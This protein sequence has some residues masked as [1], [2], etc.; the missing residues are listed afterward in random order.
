MTST[1]HHRLSRVALVLVAGGVF[2]AVALWMLRPADLSPA[3]AVGLAAA[4]LVPGFSLALGLWGLGAACPKCAGRCLPSWQPT[5]VAG[6]KASEL[7]YTCRLCG[8]TE[9]TDPVHRDDG[10]AD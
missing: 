5:I 4:A 1:T 7:V 2:V 6:S 3:V 8:R 10:N 9:L